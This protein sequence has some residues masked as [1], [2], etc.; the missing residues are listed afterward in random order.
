[1]GP[2]WNRKFKTLAL[3]I[4]ML[5]K[6]VMHSENDPIVNHVT[7]LKAK[8]NRAM[9]FKEDLVNG[10]IKMIQEGL[11]LSWKVE[12]RIPYTDRDL[13]YFYEKALEIYEDG[14]Q[15][16]EEM[17]ILIDLIRFENHKKNEEFVKR[18]DQLK[19][20]LININYNNHVNNWQA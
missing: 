19:V 7:D 17:K 14:S 6:G 12:E 15:K 11:V 18:N 1:M 3:T 4:K 13:A 10:A 20:N 9:K 5:K 2:L 8:S 16:K